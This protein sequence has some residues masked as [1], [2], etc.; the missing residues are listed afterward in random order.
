MNGNPDAE[1]KRFRE[2]LRS[3]GC[4]VT[5]GYDVHMHH[6]VGSKWK[7]KGFKKPGEWLQI[8]LHH[9]IHSTIDGFTF[10]WQRERWLESIELHNAEFGYQP[11]PEKLIEYVKNMRHKQDVTTRRHNRTEVTP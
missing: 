1:Q 4:V 10:D 11:V 6:I 2:N 9:N 8:A 7:A 5:G 3:L